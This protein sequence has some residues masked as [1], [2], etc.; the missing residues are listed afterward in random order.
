MLWLQAQLMSYVGRAEMPSLARSQ[1][2]GSGLVATLSLPT[3]TEELRTHLC[4]SHAY[5]ALTQLTHRLPLTP[6]H[7]CCS[8]TA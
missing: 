2:G 6:R 7:S 1:G 3:A 8:G 4:E 5:A